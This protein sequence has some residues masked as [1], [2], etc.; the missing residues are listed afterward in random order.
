MI[1]SFKIKENMKLIAQD[2]LHDRFQIP[3][4]DN[5]CVGC[6]CC[7]LYQKEYKD[8]LENE[9]YYNGLL[10]GTGISRYSH[11]YTIKRALGFS[12]CG[13]LQMFLIALKLLKGPEKNII[14]IEKEHK[15]EK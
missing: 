15:N 12:T 1:R 7:P 9:T 11:C 5:F 6:W 8:F 4:S 10:F 14:T 2:M 3:N 13:E